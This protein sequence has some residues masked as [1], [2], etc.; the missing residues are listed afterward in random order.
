VEEGR[1]ERRLAAILAAD[2]VGF[3]RL[4]AEDEVGTLTRLKTLRD[5]LFD[6]K[7]EKYGG[8][9]FKNTGDGALAEFTSA[10]DA[11]QSAMEIQRALTA[12]N[13]DIP[14]D[15]RIELR[16][17]I[18]L[19]DVMVDG[20]DLFGNGVNVAAR[21]EALAKPGGVCISANV[22]EHLLAGADFRFNDLGQQ[23]VKNIDRP[24]HAY[25]IETGPLT[26]DLPSAPNVDLPITDVDPVL[27]R[28]A[29]AVLP[30]DNLTHDP[31]QEYFS[32]GL[33]EDIITALSYWR[34]FPVIARNST[35]TYKGRPVKVQDV[36]KELGARYVIEGSVRKGGDRV[37]VTV[38]LIDAKT[39]HHVWAERYDRNM[40]DIFSLQDEI[41]ERIVATVEPEIERA[42]RQRSISKQPSNL[43]AWDFYLRGMAFLHEFTKDGNQR[44][45]DMFEQ[46]IALD[47]T[48]V[49]GY[50]GISYSHHRDVLLGFSDDQEQ[51]AGECRLAAEKAVALDATNPVAHFALSRAFHL[52][53]AIEQ[54]LLE[55]ESAI[56]LNPNDLLG[57]ASLG[58]ILLSADRPDDAIAA[59]G[60]A[61]QLSP[62]DPRIYLYLGL[63]SAGHFV[64]GRYE[65]AARIAKDAVNRNSDDPANRL[66]LTASLGM[67]GRTEEARTV[68]AESSSIHSD[69]LD[70]SWIFQSLPEPNRNEIRESLRLIGW[71][72]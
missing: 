4:M 9:V 3:S 23:E 44:A 69:F 15:R 62:K 27:S 60:R 11:V 22:H 1:V 71:A 18:S 6:P 47:P 30:F 5:E 55:A 13:A 34:T 57:Y 64:A 31:E 65:D 48:Y 21:M 63:Q 36:A 32:D 2:V 14:Q 26:L 49:S 72:S 29:V 41:T 42:E 59:L 24:V 10:V 52:A 51:S 66:L 54:A 53:G 12:R 19:G 17:G 25:E 39:G 58:H 33:T 37:R 70:R 46:A 68:I 28:P 45:R 16:I 38:Q 35:F 7:T 67:A 50:N 56:Q 40:D 61:L 8:R 20:D 43:Q